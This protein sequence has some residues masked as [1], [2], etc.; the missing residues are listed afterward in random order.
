MA[1]TPN[2]EKDI[3]ALREKIAAAKQKI[4]AIDAAPMPLADALTDVDWVV[5]RLRAQVA[6]ADLVRTSFAPG[7]EPRNPFDRVAE[8]AKSPWPLLCF[9][10]PTEIKARLRAVAEQYA[11]DAAA[12]LPKAQRGAAR[13]AVEREL[14]D[15]EIAEERAIVAAAE[16][17]VTIWRRADCDPGI[18]LLSD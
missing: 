14:R 15:L 10:F 7:G 18:V 11:D 1:S 9:L 16:N 2:A 5:D 6:P 4:A 17:G 12:G 8:G 13:M 3:A